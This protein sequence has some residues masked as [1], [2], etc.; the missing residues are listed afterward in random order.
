MKGK[1]TA[2]RLRWL[3]E[4]D[5]QGVIRWTGARGIMENNWRNMMNAMVGDE[6]VTPCENGGYQLTQAGRAALV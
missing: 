3:R 4:A 2:P 1:I 6:L 5:S